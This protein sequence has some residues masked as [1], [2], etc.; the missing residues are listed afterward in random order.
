MN[1]K[2][3]TNLFRMLYNDVN[4]GLVVFNIIQSQQSQCGDD[5]FIGTF[6]IVQYE[7]IWT[8]HTICE[9]HY[10]NIVEMT[11][12]SKWRS[13]YK[14]T[15]WKKSGRMQKLLKSMKVIELWTDRFFFSV[16]CFASMLELGM[17]FC[18]PESLYLYFFCGHKESNSEKSEPSST[19]LSHLA[20]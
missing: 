2:M 20:K 16:Q 7:L 1:Q 13:N 4:D 8:G 9:I 6:Q 11:G 18:W 3:N 10:S 15:L 17:R 5:M 14:I 19:S 12:T